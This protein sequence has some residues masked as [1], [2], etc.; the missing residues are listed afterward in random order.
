MRV[1]PFPIAT[2]IYFQGNSA[3][4]VPS[5]ISNK[6]AEVAEFLETHPDVRVRAIGYAHESEN[7]TR[8]PNLPLERAQA[9]QT[10]LE[11]LG[12][13]RRRVLP[14]G[15]EMPPEDVAPNQAAWLSQSVRFEI[16]P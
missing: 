13:E 4:L 11:N 8:Y 2:R 15:S 3:R 10:A 5:D 12:I 1:Q 6:L 16:L 7:R 9:V 14:E